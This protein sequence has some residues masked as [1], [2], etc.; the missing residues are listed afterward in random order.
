MAIVKMKKLSVVAVKA[1]REELLK[2]LM[3]LGC[4][5][6]SQPDTAPLLS[7]ESVGADKCTEQYDSLKSALTLLDKYSPVKTGFLSPKPEISLQAVLSEKNLEKALEIA[8]TINDT[9]DKIKRLELE[10]NHL[11][12]NIESLS[13]WK[14]MTVPFDLSETA[15]CFAVPGVIPAAVELAPVEEELA[16]AAPESQLFSV[17]DDKEMHYLLLVAMKSEK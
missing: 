10:E 11:R 12:S 5:E 6:I 3:L 2:K 8:N 9:D 4:V 16:A 7:R 13:P 1:Q 15:T 17:S 14:S